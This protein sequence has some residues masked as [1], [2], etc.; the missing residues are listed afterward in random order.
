MMDWGVRRYPWPV[1]NP[2]SNSLI[3]SIWQ[4][5]SVSM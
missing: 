5:V 2:C 3:R 1:Q 4:Q